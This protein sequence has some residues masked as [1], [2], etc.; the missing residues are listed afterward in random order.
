MITRTLKY[1]PKGW[2]V[3]GYFS[4]FFGLFFEGR[5]RHLVVVVVV[6]VVGV[7]LDKPAR[8]VCTKLSLF[9]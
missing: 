4:F 6:V 5:G 3:F 1:Y 7:C 8:N 2:V 9:S